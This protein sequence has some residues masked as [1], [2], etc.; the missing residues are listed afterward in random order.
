M[1]RISGSCH[2]KRK[3]QIID[4]YACT[5]FFE[6][7]RLSGVAG[8]LERAATACDELEAR[9]D[10]EIASCF[11]HIADTNS[12]LSSKHKELRNQLE[13]LM[14]S[15]ERSVAGVSIRWILHSP[16][17]FSDEHHDRYIY[18]GSRVIQVGTGLKLFKKT[19]HNT[20]QQSSTVTYR[21]S[22]KEHLE[23]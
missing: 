5:D 15:I 21:Y 19:P 10:I 1:S 12:E 13:C 8:F 11:P 2:R 23:K 3:I 22:S 4:R 9:L 16:T 7:G 17:V 18:F 6:Y 20:V 14:K